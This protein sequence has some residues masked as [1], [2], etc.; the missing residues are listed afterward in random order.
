MKKFN[1]P[2]DDMKTIYILFI[3]SLLKQCSS[4]WHKSLTEED[5]NSIERVQKSAFKIILQNKYESYENALK[6]LDMLSLKERREELFEKFTIH[7]Y[8]NEKLKEF[9][10]ENE[11]YTTKKLRK[12]EKYQVSKFSTERFKNST[13]IQM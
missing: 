4:L 10:K 1:P 6:R 3:R 13:I 11:K 5:N 7:N 9:F 2:I 8:K 12:I